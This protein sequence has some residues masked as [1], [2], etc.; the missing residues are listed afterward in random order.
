MA[1][2]RICI[3]A[4]VLLRVR[5]RNSYYEINNE[6]LDIIAND[7]NTNVI[8]VDLMYAMYGFRTYLKPYDLL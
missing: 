2:G 4:G 5:M 6:L 7:A 8:N 3:I 1:S